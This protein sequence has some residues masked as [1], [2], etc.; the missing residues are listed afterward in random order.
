MTYGGASM[1][2]G[3]EKKPTPASLLV[4]A[5]A[6]LAVHFAL[7]VCYAVLFASGSS[8]T[9][10][11]LM[12]LVKP[13]AALAT[14]V[15]LTWLHYRARV[16]GPTW[17]RPVTAALMI[18]TVYLFARTPW[19]WSASRAAFVAS[20]AL[21]ALVL[22][23][24]NRLVLRGRQIRT[25]ALLVS[26][27][28]L[29]TGLL[30][31]L[32]W[33]VSNRFGLVSHSPDS[34]SVLDFARMS[35]KD[36][37]PTC[38]FEYNS[39][40]YRD[41]EPPEKTAGSQRVLVVG[42]SYVWGDGIASNEETLPYRLREA[43]EL[44]SRGAFDV[45]SAAYPGIDIYGY[46]RFTEVLQPALA[47]DIVVISY[48]G[49]CSLSDAQY[50]LDRATDSEV[51]RRF[52]VRMSVLEY[53][54]EHVGRWERSAD[55]SVDRGSFCRNILED[56][57]RHSTEGGYTLLFLS[58]ASNHGQELDAFQEIR[59]PDHLMYQGESSDLWYAK[60]NHPRP[61]L[62]LLV[63]DIIADAIMQLD[64]TME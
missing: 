18:A 5:T 23:I 53:A 17:L 29:S 37:Y 31:A 42:D 24:T 52:F 48:L 49:D 4:G 27:L 54:H 32:P 61:P 9:W 63:A 44:R 47:A 34:T 25:T 64:G 55:A 57:A 46:T 3:A 36:N 59:L 13:G 45:V 14:A 51:L 58:W 38:T 2:D 7:T 16:T 11:S 28:V 12:L 19:G 21:V 10:M 8:E 50:L 60:D 26:S 22:S 43:L 39:L 35:N 30:M 1:D 6:Y 40:G 56:L 41:T 62:L 20:F 15:L 33:T